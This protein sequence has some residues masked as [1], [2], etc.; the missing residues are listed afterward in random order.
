MVLQILIS[1][2]ASFLRKDE[3]NTRKA[4]PRALWKVTDPQDRLDVTLRTSQ[5]LEVKNNIEN[6][7]CIF[8]KLPKLLGCPL[9]L[10]REYHC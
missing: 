1:T 6:G 3:E 10:S 2:L 5:S 8:N 7:E 9:N 4:S